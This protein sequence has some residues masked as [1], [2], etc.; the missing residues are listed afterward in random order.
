MTWNILGLNGIPVFFLPFLSF[1]LFLLL[2]GS[3]ASAVAAANTNVD[4][5]YKNNSEKE[6]R[7]K[8][9]VYISNCVYRANKSELASYISKYV[10]TQV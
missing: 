4:V 9:A 6:K 5:A 10:V 3:A 7:V 2:L 8:F 1:F